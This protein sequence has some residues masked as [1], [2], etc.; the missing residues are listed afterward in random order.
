VMLKVLTSP[1]GNSRSIINAYAELGISATPANNAEDLLDASHVVLPG[2]GNFGSLAKFLKSNGFDESLNLCIQRGTKILG[3]CVGMQVLFASSEESP[4]HSGLGLF[5][6]RCIKLD[7][8]IGKV[9]HVGWVDVIKIKEHPVLSGLTD[10]FPAYFS[11]SFHVPV[12]PGFTISKT[13]DVFSVS[14][15]VAKDNI[16]GSQFHPEKSQKS[17]LMFLNNFFEWKT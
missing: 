5:E 16:L 4:D 1:Y 13:D 6:N 14:A 15:I 9:P 11:H 12:N 8:K 7:S 10:S 2:V 3:V 17:G